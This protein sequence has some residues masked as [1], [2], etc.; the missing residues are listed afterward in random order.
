MPQPKLKWFLSIISLLEMAREKLRQIIEDLTTRYDVDKMDDD[1]FY[2]SIIGIYNKRYNPLSYSEFCEHKKKLW[3][4]GVCTSASLY[5]DEFLI[6]N[7]NLPSGRN[8]RFYMNARD[9]E[10][11]RK[12]I[13]DTVKNM[14]NERQFRIKTVGNGNYGYDRYDNIVVYVNMSADIKYFA[15]FLKAL[16]DNNKELFDDEVPFPARKIARGIG[17]GTSVFKMDHILFGKYI[18]KGDAV[19]F[20]SLHAC[21]LNLLFSEFRE[22]DILDLDEKAELYVQ[23]LKQVR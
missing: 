8:I 17:Y 4:H 2:K 11:A 13:I 5:G 12:I 7:N 14:K 18:S 6:Y 21:V 10:S 20:N 9:A 22:R 23:A 15:D 19:S 3:D 1:D 16:S